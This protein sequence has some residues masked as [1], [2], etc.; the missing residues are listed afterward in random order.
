MALEGLADCGIAW[1]STIAENTSEER[2][3]CLNTWIP[4]DGRQRVLHAARVDGWMVMHVD[5]RA[6][7]R[8]TECRFTVG[9][10]EP[11]TPEMPEMRLILSCG[12]QWGR[13]TV[14]SETVEPVRCSQCRTLRPRTAFS[15]RQRR[16]KRHPTCMA[17]TAV[18]VDLVF[19]D[20]SELRCKFRAGTTVAGLKEWFARHRGVTATA[21]AVARVG[22]DVEPRSDGHVLESRTYQVLVLE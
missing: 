2:Y 16:Q 22:V 9:N 15:E 10:Q 8:F 12:S 11:D 21:V 13:L 6:A 5:G 18:T 19:L 3:R 1:R 4:N 14:H 20:G 7:C 17:C